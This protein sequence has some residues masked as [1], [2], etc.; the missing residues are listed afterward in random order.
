MRRLILP[1]TCLLVMCLTSCEKYIILKPVI[2]EGISYSEKVQPIFD[3]KCVS[4]HTGM[5]P[6]LTPEESYNSLIS[7]NYVD[8]L[9]PESS[10]IYVKLR[11]THDSRA[12]EEDKLT[13]LQWITEGALNN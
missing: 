9:D 11:T 7:G 1:V 8:T 2:E 3:S 12:T 13:I 4:C 6:V 10:V 5:D